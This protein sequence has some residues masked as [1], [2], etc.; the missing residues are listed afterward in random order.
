LAR[1][2]SALFTAAWAEAISAAVAAVVVFLSWFCAVANASLAFATA[3]CRSVGSSVIKVCPAVTTSPALTFTWSTRPAALKTRFTDFCAE[4][5]PAAL[6]LS[7]KL[8]RC[9]AAVW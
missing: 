5:V 7:T 3:A 6:T 8:P 1:F 4:M 9:T 2:A